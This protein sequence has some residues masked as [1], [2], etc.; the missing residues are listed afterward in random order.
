MPM[1]AK[2]Y[3]EQGFGGKVAYAFDPLWP[4]LMPYFQGGMNY[5]LGTTSNLDTMFFFGHAGLSYR[6]FVV[7]NFHIYP[8]PC[9]RPADWAR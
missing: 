4:G 9:R 2:D 6:F 7:R 5:T 1:G 8:L 3:V